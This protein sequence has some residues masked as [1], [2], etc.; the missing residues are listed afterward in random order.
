MSIPRV[1]TSDK[2]NIGNLSKVIFNKDIL[3]ISLFGDFMIGPL[4]GFTDAWSATFLHEMYAIDRHI[5]YSISKWILIGF[6]VL[7]FPYVLVKYPTRT[8]S[9]GEQ[10]IFGVNC[11][12]Y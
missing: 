5:A 12:N 1:G 7:L 8:C 6:G 4:E 2:I 11:R 9:N 3:L 10:P